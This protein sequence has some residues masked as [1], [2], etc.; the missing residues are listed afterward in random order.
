MQYF[1]PA[2]MRAA[3]HSRVPIQFSRQVSSMAH[4]SMSTKSDSVTSVDRE[5]AIDFLKS[6]NRGGGRALTAELIR[7]LNELSDDDIQAYAQQNLTH[8]I[9]AS[10]LETFLG[11]CP[12]GYKKG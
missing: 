11:P 12:N 3:T 10:S 5:G 2:A 1:L 6:H 8:P 9:Q 7:A 4:Q